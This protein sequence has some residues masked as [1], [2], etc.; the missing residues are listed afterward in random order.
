MIEAGAAESVLKNK[1]VISKLASQ[2]H[3]VSRP[4]SSYMESQ[5][6]I[7]WKTNPV[8]NYRS[9]SDLVLHCDLVFV[10]AL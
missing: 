4:Y 2:N 7:P 8:W 6:C 1:K 10:A 5:L 3:G 9:L